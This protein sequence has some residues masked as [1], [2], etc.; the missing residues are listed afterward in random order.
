MCT[1]RSILVVFLKICTKIRT[2]SMVLLI[3]IIPYRFPRVLFLY[4]L[5]LV[6]YSR[7]FVILGLNKEYKK[8]KIYE[9]LFFRRANIREARQ[10]LYL[11]TWLQ[12]WI[13][14][15]F[16]PTLY[17]K[18]LNYPFVHI[19]CQW[20]LNNMISFCIKMLYVRSM[21]EPKNK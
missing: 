16:L 9:H 18:K 14:R 12:V 21:Y 13:R 2:W 15:P 8:K 11:T 3:Y 5:Y 10:A 1:I 7:I 17:L 4:K 6:N 20:I 19:F